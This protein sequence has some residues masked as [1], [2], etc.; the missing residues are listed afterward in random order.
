M[1][2]HELERERQYWEEKEMY[3]QRAVDYAANQI[4]K[5]SQRI[6]ELAFTEPHLTLVPP[7]EEDHGTASGL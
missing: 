4:E 5:L 1:K 2:R 6:V 7:L 3:A